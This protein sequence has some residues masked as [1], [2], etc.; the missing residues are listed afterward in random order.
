MSSPL[1]GHSWAPQEDARRQVF[2]GFPYDEP[3]RSRYGTRVASAIGEAEWDPVMPLD[4]EP[5]GLLLDQIT[6]MIA[7]SQRAVYEVGPENG[8]VWFELGFSASLRQPT[9]LLSDRDPAEL[10]GILRSPW[11]QLYADEQACADAVRG[12]LGL[13]NAAPIVPAPQGLG[14]PTLVVVVGTGDRAR[15]IQEAIRAS[16][17]SVVSHAPNSIRS[18]AEAVKL[19][20]SCGVLVVVRPHGASWKGS[21]AV[22][23]LATAGAA[24]GLRHEVFVAAGLDEWVPTDCEQLTV[25]ATDDANLSVNL[26]GQIA[27]APAAPP[28]SGTARPRIPASL[29]RSLRTPVVEAL[30]NS[31]RVLLSAEPGYG[32][33]T[34]LHQ[35]ASE[36]AHPTAWVTMETNSSAAQL[37]EQV[38]FAVGQHVPGFGWD[39][40]AALR[41]SQQAAR[42]VAGRIMPPPAPQVTQL[43]EMLARDVAAREP[44]LLVVDDI[45]RATG[46]AAQLLARLARSGPP[47]LRIAFAGR[48]PPADIRTDA[49]SGLLPSWGAEELRF[50]RDETR[51]Y[52]R[53][54]V[55]GLDDQ[56]ADLL[57]ERTEGW[58]AALAVIR[59]WLSTHPD[60]T[61]ST[62]REMARGD[63][64]QVY[65][66]FAT[67]YFAALQEDI[68]RELLISSV[69]VRLDAAVARH[70]LGLQ[71]ATRLRA[72]VDGPYFF[73]EEEAGTFRLHTLFREFLQ[74]RW[75]EERGQ[76]SLQA[77]QSDLARWY[78]KKEDLLSAYQIACE[79]EDWEAAVAAIEPLVRGFANQ[80]DAGFLKGLLDPIPPERIRESRPVW[81]SWVRALAHTGAK[82]ALAE[83]RALAA[84]GASTVVD[85]AI[86]GLLLAELEHDLGY[87]DDQ[88]L[89]DACSDIASRVADH[90]V[91]L[92]LSARLLSLDARAT[93]NANPDEWGALLGEAQQLLA[94]AEA[95][96]A[97]LLAAGACATAADLSNRIAQNELA[98]EYLEINVTRELGRELPLEERVE[99]AKSALARNSDIIDLFQKAFRLAEA[100]G[101][102]LVE[103]RVQLGYARF[104]TY[105]MGQSLIRSGGTDEKAGDLLQYALGNALKAAQTYNEMGIPRDVAI[106][107][108]AAAEAASALGDRDRLDEYTQ[109]S[110]RIAQQYGYLE[111]AEAAARIREE[112]MVLEQRQGARGSPQS[113]PEQVEEFVDKLI[114]FSGL[115]ET[116]AQRVRPVIRK[117]VEDLD[118]L[119]E[120]RED[121]CQYLALLRNLRGPKVGPF[122]MDLDWRVIC[123]L[124]G[125]SWVKVGDQ[126]EPLLDEFTFAFCPDCKFRSP[127]VAGN[128]PGNSFEEIYAPMLDWLARESE[129]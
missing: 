32:K 59:A 55:P 70:L 19:A 120:R 15:S 58:P 41:R 74:R 16:G 80:G 76:D 88:S 39:A 36:L 97:P 63:R 81:E 22:A 118:I 66:V 90:D 128:E 10:A 27:R 68:Q 38:V 3:Y 7:G 9:A 13:E 85:Q 129:S 71:G 25:R 67:D 117:E 23:T 89:A 93:R 5:Q 60:A 114:R 57:H 109:E 2:L 48:E 1:A 20:E 77:A 11:L 108:N 12:F 87:L 119:L 110:S 96:D 28:P 44:V 83:A 124:R 17:R 42:Q 69:P 72:L 26:L 14:D 122:L 99:R 65:R 95:A 78:H 43:A 29:Q 123:R 34:L 104:L 86:A 127:G 24:L 35:V 33:T 56:R 79:G 47:W 51:E 30:R 98:S 4:K 125:L 113:T 84:A 102:L 111:I 53:A 75:V 21:D 106:A 94:E 82:G 8:N 101:S 54:S 31:G 92:F 105:N 100:A 37:V 91:S 52:L 45:Q 103:A 73:A 18:L 50:S 46:D 64:H 115:A 61:I 62:L 112:P 121:V 116:D 107:L 40:W 126:A 6:S 49:A